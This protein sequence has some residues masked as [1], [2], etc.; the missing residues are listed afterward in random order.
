[1]ASLRNADA[2]LRNYIRQHSLP[3]IYEALLCGLCA[4]CPENPLQFLEEKIKEMLETGHHS[5]LWDSYI[6]DSRKP[7]VKAMAGS[8]FE[9]LYG[10]DEDQL[11]SPELFKKAY[12]FY[13]NKLQKLYF[14]AWMEYCARRKA[15]RQDTQVKLQNAEAHHTKSILQSIIRR[16]DKWVKFRNKQHFK[17]STKIQGVFDNAFMKKILKAWNA[18]T[19]DS[20]KKREYFERLERGEM[21]DFG[22][23]SSSA[24]REGED[25]ISQLPQ[26]ALFKIFGFMDLIDLARI[27]Q[28]CRSWKIIAQNSLLWNSIDF[29]SVRHRIQDKFVINILRKCRPYVIRLNLRRCSTLHWSTFKGIGECRNLQDLNLSE[30]RNVNEEAIKVICEGCPALLYLNLSHTEIT[31][32]TIRAMSRYLLNLQYLSVAYSRKFTDKG[33]QYLGSGKGCHKIIYLDLSGCTQISV[34]GFRYLADGCSSLQHLKIND[35][36]TLTD[37]CITTL[38]EKCQNIL[39][40]SLL[41]S[42]HLSD[43]AFKILAQGRKLE[44]IRIEGNSLI[45]DGSIKAIGRSSPY[46][47]HIYIANCQKITDISLKAIASLKNITVLNVADCIRI[48]DPG[49]RQVVEG[50]SGNK[51]RELNLTNCLRVSDLSLLR[52]AQK[53]HNLNFLSLRFCENVTDSGIELLG[54]MASLIS[55]DISGTSITDQGLAALGAQSKIRELSVSEC[56]GITDIGIQ[57]FCHQSKD[58]EALDISHC[59]Q[60]SNN[61]VKTIA[62]C[63]KM[64]TSI[65]ISG[66][67]K[68]TDISIQ[69]LS[70]GCRYLHIID[71]SGDIHLSDKALKYLQKGCRQLRTLRM[72]YC[73]SITKAA[74]LKIESKYQ[75]VEYGTDDPPPWFGYDRH[76]NLLHGASH[77]EETEE[78]GADDLYD[79]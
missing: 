33:L 14:D 38:L 49:V 58:L 45:T 29:S 51:I 55:I 25:D 19:Q 9:Y 44:K 46:L 72:R 21:D 67:P 37:N 43:A 5:L 66:C 12:S 63:C 1:M 17:A 59:L 69:Y 36:F 65:N 42:P 78:E 24:M 28:V 74:V 52:I 40:I 26:R 57:K 71:I 53:C 75:N 35:M 18:E 16:W 62:F 2:Q 32:T 79:I 8:Y 48:S 68:I 70:G 15:K 50:P 31:N 47:N 56:Q 10:Q 6:D 27:A 20:K 13:I 54:N 23:V 77:V 76:G 61:T 41:G 30:C 34:D 22:N 3:H 64:L 73:K 60:V 39:S 11:V 4:M 7:K